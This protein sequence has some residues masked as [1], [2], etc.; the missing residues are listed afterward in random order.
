MSALTLAQQ[1]STLLSNTFVFS[2]QL[3]SFHWLLRGRGFNSM[4][5][6]LGEDYSNVYESVD[7]YAEQVLTL[8]Y[9][10]PV[11]LSEYLAL[12][13]SIREIPRISDYEKILHIAY[14][15]HQIIGNLIKEVYKTAEECDAFDISN[16]LG[17]RQ[18][19]HFKKAWFYRAELGIKVPSIFEASKAPLQTNPLP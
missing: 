4:H 1:I 17:E 13:T 9:E 3:H 14:S 18:G 16:Y 10:P 8:E 7:I 2:Q 6:F 12:S 15:S 11:Q 5:T 19:Y